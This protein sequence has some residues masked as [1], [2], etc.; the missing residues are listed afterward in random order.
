MNSTWVKPAAFVLGGA[1]LLSAATATEAA[2]IDLKDGSGASVGWVA[3]IPDVDVGNINLTFARLSNGTYFF[4]KTATITRDNDPLI[5]TFQKTNANAPALAIAN[6]AVTNKSAD[7]WIGYRIFVSSGTDSSGT[8]AYT[9]SGSVGTAGG[10]TID[11]FTTF[12][13]AN[14]SQDLV[15]GGGTVNVGQTWTPGAVDGSGLLIVNSGPS[16]DHFS[17]KEIPI[18]IPLPAAVWTGLSSLIGLAVLKSARQRH[19]A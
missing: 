6:E 4:T 2:Q 10:F 16:S 7:P 11:P 13:F 3:N 17:L 18:P 15:L 19:S 14:D 5:I 9:L 8:P 1:L 12:A